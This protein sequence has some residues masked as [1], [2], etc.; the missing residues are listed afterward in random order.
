MQN[1]ETRNILTTWPSGVMPLVDFD[2]KLGLIWSAKSACSLSV[3]WF[4]AVTGHIQA[5]WAL[6]KW[7]HKYRGEVFN[8]L[9][10]AA[11]EHNSLAS[12]DTKWVRVMRDPF[13]R[14]VSSYRHFLLFDLER[15][16]AD[17][18][19]GEP[20]NERGLSFEEF[21]A[22]LETRDIN[23][24]DIH[25][26]QQWVTG[27]ECCLQP[28]MINADTSDVESILFGIL[29]PDD[30]SMKIFYECKDWLFPLHNARIE[31]MPDI[32]SSYI[33]KRKRILKKWPGFAAFDNV[34]TRKMVGKI[35]HEDYERFGSVI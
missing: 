5:A 12:A 33:L 25:L 31:E 18:F 35:Y 24:C 9:Q 20:V 27:E 14:A 6:A 19:F 13:K 2:K 16:E 21:L 7:P 4:F 26:R 1:N 28:V 15:A 32:N 3:L 22:Y 10:F 23:Q 34:T 11:A 8:G 29:K 30:E 17:A